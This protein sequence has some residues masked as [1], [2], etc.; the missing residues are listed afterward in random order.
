MTAG[1]SLRGGQVAFNDAGQIA[2]HTRTAEGRHVLF[3]DGSRTEVVHTQ[4][5]GPSSAAMMLNEKGELLFTA[6]P[7]SYRWS[8]GRGLE[9]L[10]PN[11]DQITP[12][13]IAVDRT[14]YVVYSGGRVAIL[15]D[16][17][18]RDLGGFAPVGGVSPTAGLVFGPYR[19]GTAAIYDPTAQTYDE[20]PWPA[21]GGLPQIG[22]VLDD[23]TVVFGT[24]GRVYQLNSTTSKVLDPEW[25][26]A[27]AQSAVLAV[28]RSGTQVLASQ[29]SG[30]NTRL[31][32]LSLGPDGWTWSEIQRSF[33]GEP[34]TALT[35][36]SRGDV[37][38]MRASTGETLVWHDRTGWR[39]A[40]FAGVPTQQALRPV[41]I[42]ASGTI[43]ASTAGRLVL[44][45]PVTEGRA[46]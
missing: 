37:A 36:G 17:T 43:L 18:A 12:H 9:R 27:P 15:P 3:F 19:E 23:K 25:N 24:A 11:A 34:V 38:G 26:G 2:G 16:G 31:V 42:D 21:G 39:P 1:A 7:G 33:S 32:R 45:N 41:G 28:S 46:P 29:S 5:P 30:G 6:G 10:L 40:Q 22:V 35:L 4:P 8:T 20:F 13:L 14:V 44:L